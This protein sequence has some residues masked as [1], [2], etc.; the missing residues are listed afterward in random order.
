[1]LN[2]EMSCQSDVAKGGFKVVSLMETQLHVIYSYY[3]KI[4]ENQKKISKEKE[5]KQKLKQKKLQPET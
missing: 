2:K 5:Q 1:M 3:Q 4:N